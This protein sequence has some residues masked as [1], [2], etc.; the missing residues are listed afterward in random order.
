M[1][2]QTFRGKVIALTGGGQ[3][4]GLATARILASRGASLS[5]ADSNPAT[6]AEVEQEFKEKNWP[7]HVETVDVR[8][9]ESV[10]SWID[11]T[12]KKFERLDGAANIAGTV[13]RQIFKAPV[14]DIDDDDW[15]LVLA[16]NVT[17]NNTRIIPGMTWLNPP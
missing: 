12:V 8:S 1:S 11:T 14:V 2:D 3:G 9:R 4:I 15:N 10:D 6:L 17:G 5:L 13:G 7:V 16:V